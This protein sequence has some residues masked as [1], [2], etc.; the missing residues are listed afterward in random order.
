MKAVVLFPDGRTVSFNADYYAED[1]QKVT[2]YKKKEDSVT[3]EMIETGRFFI[4]QIC[5]FCL[6]DK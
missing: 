4:N 3:G 5:G 6:K 1:S 2:F